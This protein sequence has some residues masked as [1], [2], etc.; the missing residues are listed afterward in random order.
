MNR[1]LVVGL[2]LLVACG[3]CVCAPSPKR[4]R[5]VAG[6]VR[7]VRRATSA[8][9][10]LLR[11][12]EEAAALGRVENPSAKQR[13]RAAELNALFERDMRARDGVPAPFG[14]AEE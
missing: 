6:G 5:A 10:S 11:A 8:A 2:V 4:P 9:T 1:L 3:P 7:K 12:I 14:G 13:A